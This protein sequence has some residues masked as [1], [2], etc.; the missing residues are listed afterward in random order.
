MR[1]SRLPSFT[2]PTPSRRPPFRENSEHFQATHEPP[3]VS[4]WVVRALNL[5]LVA[6]GV[7]GVAIHRTEASEAVIRPPTVDGIT[8]AP[9]GELTTC[10]KP[11]DPW[12]SSFTSRSVRSDGD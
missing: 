10:R 12:P 6:L 4:R 11:L 7:A 2:P 8:R 9:S 3:N 1:P 5:L